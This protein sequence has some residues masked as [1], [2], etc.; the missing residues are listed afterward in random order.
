MNKF[1]LVLFNQF[2]LIQ[3][4]TDYVL[5]SRIYLFIFNN[6]WNID[7]YSY[8]RSCIDASSFLF[9]FFAIAS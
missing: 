5:I 9:F 8:P 7:L 3:V 4:I 6:W 1:M 2:T